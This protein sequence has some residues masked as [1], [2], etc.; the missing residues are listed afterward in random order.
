MGIFSIDRSS[1]ELVDWNEMSVRV[2]EDSDGM[3]LEVVADDL[4]VE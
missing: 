2:G 3:A 1:N 4:A